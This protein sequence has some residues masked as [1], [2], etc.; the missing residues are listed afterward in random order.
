M[1]RFQDW[2]SARERGE[3]LAATLRERPRGPRIVAGPGWGTAERLVVRGRVVEER[4]AGED[5]DPVVA[6]VDALAGRHDR[7]VAGVEVR[8]R[9]GDIEV[10]ARTGSDGAFTLTVEGAGFDRRGWHAVTLT[11]PEHGLEAAVGV[12]A[13][14]RDSRLG[15]ASTLEGVATEPGDLAGPVRRQATEGEPA[16]SP[17][18]GFAG[19]VE[20]LRRDVMAQPRNPIF[21]VADAPT[22]LVEATLEAQGLPAGPMLARSDRGAPLRE[23]FETYPDLDFVVVGDLDADAA[24]LLSLVEDYPGQVRAA[25][26]RRPA[27]A[28]LDIAL[29]RTTRALVDAGVEVVLSDDVVPCA[30]HAQKMGWIRERDL[31]RIRSARNEDVDRARRPTSLRGAA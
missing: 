16:P 1:S 2:I 14:R 23:V 3:E 17:F 25:Y 15:I 30:E 20:A 22:E 8:A 13:A 28:A 21:Y 18:A 27:G 6:L 10:S 12:Q 24:L 19:L 11:V 29:R 26:L 4:D 5:E 9:C 7:P 31:P